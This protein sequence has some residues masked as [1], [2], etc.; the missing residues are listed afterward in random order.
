MLT[1]NQVMDI[2]L[3]YNET[4]DWEQTMDRCLPKRK[5]KERESDTTMG[6]GQGVTMAHDDDDDEEALYNSTLEKRATTIKE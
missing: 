6:E 1:V 4:L 3:A 5:I 2:L